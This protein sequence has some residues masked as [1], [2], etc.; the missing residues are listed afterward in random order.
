MT[1]WSLLNSPSNTVACSFDGQ[2]EHICATALYYYDDC[3]V[4]EGDPTFRQQSRGYP[5]I[6]NVNTPPGRYGWLE[7]VFG[8]TTGPPIQHMGWIRSLEGRVVTYPNILQTMADPLELEDP[9][10]PGHRKVLALFLVDP[11]I[12]IISTANVPCQQREWWTDEVMWGRSMLLKL[13]NE[14]RSYVLEDVDQISGLFDMEK[15]QRMAEEMQEERETLEREHRRAACE[16]NPGLHYW[17]GWS[18]SRIDWD[19]QYM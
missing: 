2:N 12:K 10:Q 13:P 9:T 4:K 19:I 8:C 16:V 5:D 11:G 3:N 17:R 6:K 7:P 14:I 15:A 1:F 18:Y